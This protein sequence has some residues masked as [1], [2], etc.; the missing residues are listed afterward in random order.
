MVTAR[1][2]ASDRTKACQQV[3]TVLKKH[4]DPDGRFPDLY[5]KT[6]KEA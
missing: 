4:Y 1:I 2:K 3:V 6:C 5:D